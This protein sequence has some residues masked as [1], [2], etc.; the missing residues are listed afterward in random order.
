VPT[1]LLSRPDRVGDVIIATAC[2]GLI[3]HQRPDARLVFMARESMRPLLENHPLLDGFIALPTPNKSGFFTRLNDLTARISPY[4]ADALV[5]LHPELLCELAG[6]AARI[7]QRFGY[8]HSALLDP[9][10]LT[11]RFT[12]R[13]R[14]GRKHEGEYNFDLLAPLGIASPASAD[15]L[16]P[17][18]H[19][20][21]R[22]RESLRAKLGEAAAVRDGSGY[23]VL[24]PTAYSLDLRWP[25]EAF[26]QLA[27]EA[28]G[29]LGRIVLVAERA[30]DPSIVEIRRCLG[31]D[32][33]GLI[34]LS[35]RTNLAELG[36]LLHG[37]RVLV[38][39]NTGTSHLAAA[40]GCPTVE[41]FGRLEPI[42]GPDRWRALG[43]RTTI[44]RAQPDARRRGESKR[45]WWRRAHAAI[46]APE[47]LRAALELARA[48]PSSSA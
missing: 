48:A 30:D 13:R 2:F 5:H 18:V 40:V 31:G 36:W 28:A 44:I 16:Q 4:K 21:E 8:R 41:L 26:A 6:R 46:P 10:T 37:A 11:R 43:G 38:T 29:R 35:G 32:F 12:D 9:F 39:R 34:D 22:W 27:R 47:V 7:P 45:D 14:E 24:N 19:L 17:C 1:F 3:R 23:T 25:A 20:D 33:P 15:E 42:Y